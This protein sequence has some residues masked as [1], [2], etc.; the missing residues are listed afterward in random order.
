M[1]RCTKCRKRKTLASFYVD[2]TR[3]DGKNPWCK[4]CHYKKSVEWR[5]GNRKRYNEL[6]KNNDR[7]Y[8]DKIHARSV[9]NHALR[10]GKIKKKPCAICDRKSLVHA[11]H[12]DYKK[13]L[14]VIWLCT[15]HHAAL[16]R[17]THK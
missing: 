13:P 2:K 9:T 15:K 6:S 17:S 11:H 10:I 1:K 3:K 14:E 12:Y 5:E 4:P 8:K 7:L 16:H